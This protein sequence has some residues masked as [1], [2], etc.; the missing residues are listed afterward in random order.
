[1]LNTLVYVFVFILLIC[2][3]LFCHINVFFTKRL[4]LFVAV[5]AVPPLLTTLILSNFDPAFM[6]FIGSIGQWGCFV[7]IV[8]TV[9]V[10]TLLQVYRST[11]VP[12]RLKK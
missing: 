3:F 7:V 11:D 12:K 5:V 10:I 4:A 2:Y 6:D 1:M 8:L 9:I